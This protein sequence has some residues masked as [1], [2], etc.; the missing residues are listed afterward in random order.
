MLTLFVGGCATA[1]SDRQTPAPEPQTQAQTAPAVTPATAP[2]TAPARPI[3]A[4]GGTTRPAATAPAQAL[5]NAAPID[6][7]D[8]LTGSALDTSG[9]ELGAEA[10]AANDAHTVAGLTPEQYPDVFDRMRAGFKLDDI[11]SPRIDQQLAFYANN[12]QYLERVFGRA[13]LYL[14]HIVQ[15]IESRGMPLE[16]ALLPVVES[17]FE[18][19]AQSWVRANGLWQFM[20]G[21]GERD[22]PTMNVN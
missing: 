17:A 18:P 13:G 20:P 14:H 15:E 11:D 5:S 2:R 10:L 7:F 1:P 3:A 21:T 16:L 22:K 4:S 8:S 19:Y 9:A 12:P 6:A